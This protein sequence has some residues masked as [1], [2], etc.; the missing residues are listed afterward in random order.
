MADACEAI[1]SDDNIADTTTSD[2]FQEYIMHAT[3]TEA[4]DMLEES[5]TF[6]STR[7][8][9]ATSGGSHVRTAA[10]AATTGA[11]GR[12]M[13]RGAA[14][15]CMPRGAAC[16]VREGGQVERQRPLNRAEE[17]RVL[18]SQAR[19]GTARTDTTTSAA[20]GA[21]RSATRGVASW[22]LPARPAGHCA[23][24]YYDLDST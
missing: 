12:C 21:A 11:A 2:A 14:C 20:R 17:R 3:R 13:P 23:H 24:R 9:S 18:Q 6:Y 4:T 19:Q 22:G 1:D 8:A 16:Q 15:R 7:A 5:T 10:M